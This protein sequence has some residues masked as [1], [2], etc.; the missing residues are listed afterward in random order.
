[1]CER[2]NEGVG[3]RRQVLQGEHGERSRLAELERFFRPKVPFAFV[4]TRWTQDGM[5]VSMDGSDEQQGSSGGGGPSVWFRTLAVPKSGASTDEYEDAAAVREEAWPV[6]AAVA[7]GATESVFA[8]DWAETLA[9]GLCD[10]EVTP[11]AVIETLADWQI[12]WRDRISDRVAALPWYGDAKAR[13]GALATLLGVELQRG[14]CWR[15]MGIGDCLLVHLRGE[16]VQQ[17]WPYTAPD[18]FT[19]RPALVQ[20]RSGHSSSESEDCRALTGTWQKG[21]TF[22]LATDAVAAWLLRTGPSAARTWTADG[23]REAVDAARAEGVLRNDDCTL[24]VLKLTGPPKEDAP[25]S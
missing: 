18:D 22:L 11:D 9:E 24:L 10:I 4:P 19:N 23:F 8:R 21:D 12:A 16:T 6:R 20:S 15:A 5:R 13:E 25:S 2:G 3:E 7:D 1:M 14:G 17:A